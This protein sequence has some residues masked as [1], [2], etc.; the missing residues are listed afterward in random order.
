MDIYLLGYMGS[1][2]TTIGQLLAKQIGYDFVDY[3]Q[4][5]SQKENAS[6][7]DVFTAKGEI[8]FRKKE[9]LYLKELLKETKT[10]K[11]V[12]LGGGT[13]CYGNNMQ[14]IKDS[15]VISVYLNVPVTELTRRLWDEKSQRPLIANQESKEALEEFVRKHL[16]ER[17]FY[18]NQ[19]SKVIK[20]NG[21]NESQIVE[22]I[23]ATLF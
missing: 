1:G 23:I 9:A 20:V 19:A 13:P 4:F 18:Y 5:I 22:E 14:D 21:Q 6:I 2:K 15:N 10:K 17:S 11:I 16:F 7:S 8:Y 3:D 12:S